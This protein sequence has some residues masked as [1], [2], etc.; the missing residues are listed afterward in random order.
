MIPLED[1]A[2]RRNRPL[3]TVGLIFVNGM[4]FL[5]ELLLPRSLKEEFFYFLGIVPARFT[6]PDWAAWVGFPV[7][8]YWPFLT[9]LFLHSGWIHFLGNMWT[10][11]IFGDNVEDRM[12]SLRFLLFYLLCG[13]FAGIV[14]SISNPASMLPAVGASGAIA[15]VMGA[16]LFLFPNSR[17]RV[18]FPLFLLPFFFEVHTVTFFGAWFLTQI[19]GGVL[20][21]AS[22]AGGVAWWGHLGG[23]AAGVLFYRFFLKPIQDEGGSRI[24]FGIERLPL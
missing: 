16:Y 12:G 18:F 20:A 10:L 19:L 24:K 23:F 8:D 5:Y 11:W 14:H 6:H 22:Q 13:L 2:P 9:H 4:I 17:V 1:T 21:D 15:G 7:D 3:I